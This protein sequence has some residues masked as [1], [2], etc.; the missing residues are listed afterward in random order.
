VHRADQLAAAEGMIPRKLDLTDLN[1][2]AFFN[3]EDED[4]ELPS[5]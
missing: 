3:F 1:L 5:H 4:L 2:G